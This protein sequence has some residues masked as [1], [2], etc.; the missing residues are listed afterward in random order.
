MTWRSGAPIPW[1]V[2]VCVIGI[3]RRGGD[4]KVS[5]DVLCF[6]HEL[7]QDRGAYRVGGTKIMCQILGDVVGK[8]ARNCGAGARGLRR[9][10][11]GN[12]DAG[13]GVLLRLELCGAQTGG[14]V[15]QGPEFCSAKAGKVQI[16]VIVGATEFVLTQE[17]WWSDFCLS[18]PE[19]Q[20]AT[21]WVPSCYFHDMLGAIISYSGRECILAGM[22]RSMCEV[23]LVKMNIKKVETNN[24][25]CIPE[26]GMS[27]VGNGRLNIEE[28]P[29]LAQLK[30]K[31]LA[32]SQKTDLVENMLDDTYTNSTIISPLTPLRARLLA[33]SKKQAPI[34]QSLSSN[35]DEISLLQLVPPPLILP[36]TAEW[37]VYITVVTPN[38]NIYVRLLGEDYSIIYEN[39]ATD[40][41]LYYMNTIA[42]VDNPIVGNYYAIKL[43]DCWHRVLVQE[44]QEQQEGR[45]FFIDQ[46]DEE[47]HPLS[48]LCHLEPKF[49]Q[50][51]AQAVLCRLHGLEE[52][53]HHPLTCGI[54]TSLVVGKSMIAKLIPQAFEN[55]QAVP[56]IVFDTHTD[57]DV[58][59]NFLLA[60]SITH[61]V[62]HH[63]DLP[64]DILSFTSL[65]AT[66]P[67]S[68]N[69]TSAATRLE[70]EPDD[71]VLNGEGKRA[72]K[73]ALKDVT[74]TAAMTSFL[75]LLVIKKETVI[76]KRLDNEDCG[77]PVVEIHQ[78]LN[79]SPTS[80]NASIAFNERKYKSLLSPV[81]ALTYEMS[82]I[83]VQQKKQS[84]VP[85]R[86]LTLGLDKTTSQANLPYPKIPE[87][88]TYY[89][90]KTL[91]LEV[92][93][94]R[95]Y[96]LSFHPQI[97]NARKALKI[98]V[99]PLEYK[100][101]FSAMMESMQ[102]FY[103][104]SGLLSPTV[105]NITPGRLYA[106][107]HTDGVWYSGLQPLSFR[108]VVPKLWFTYHQW[109]VQLF[110]LVRIVKP[111]HCD[112]S[113]EDGVIFQNM[114][115]DREFVALVHEITK[116]DHD[117]NETILGLSL[118]DTSNS[119][120]LII[121]SNPNA[122]S[123]IDS[124]MNSQ[125]NMTTVLLGTALQS[126]FISEECIKR[127]YPPH[128]KLNIP[129]RDIAQ[130]NIHSNKGVVSCKLKLCGS[131]G[132]Q[133]V[134]ENI[135]LERTTDG[136]LSASSPK[137]TK[138]PH[139]AI[140]VQCVLS[141]LSPAI[142]YTLLG[143]C[144]LKAREARMGKGGSTVLEHAHTVQA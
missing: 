47:W 103:N 143:S 30:K 137:E 125:S 135:I 85:H 114:V 88:G 48:S 44:I 84:E 72:I 141:L 5:L 50:I 81:E 51:P 112:W 49:A 86:S 42:V 66:L 109:D 15:A 138:V 35:L 79:G 132:F 144:V 121:A 77:L 100:W 19:V 94:Q 142:I 3:P 61:S 52:F 67:L 43:D 75:K 92:T 124:F 98:K 2:L 24:G 119:K 9:E 39:M 29:G 130:T 21:C 26:R 16:E 34:L 96:S 20:V 140:V 122:L 55:D 117:S 89:D 54:L 80:L 64:V 45:L 65:T 113:T 22:G 8:S 110:P 74:A 33:S 118:I 91:C 83:A 31:F 40:M 73:V 17:I 123:Q 93:T 32:P 129:T 6:R 57:D 38:A 106:A 36:D 56:V 127:L 107:L 11:R 97:K 60:E 126:S 41:E 12:C 87:I 128:R 131:I 120:D 82:N 101:Q 68:L 116:D 63:F 69:P 4:V 1:I 71:M 108:S 53:I 46:G 62:S 104:S 10:G 14:I 7:I 25:T 78:I 90:V 136:I 27:N 105:N 76:L 59:I 13:A 133:L 18:L 134:I 115:L 28:P 37:D 70:L 58:N 95:T 99:Q 111:C 23:E 139:Q 102:N